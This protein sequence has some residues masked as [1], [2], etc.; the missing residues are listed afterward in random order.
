MPT[1]ELMVGGEVLIAGWPDDALHG[2]Q[3][4]HLPDTADFSS[5]VPEKMVGCIPQIR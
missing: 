3:G 2:F 5:I 4:G 1:L